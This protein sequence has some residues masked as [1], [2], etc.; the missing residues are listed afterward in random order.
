MR[1]SGRFSVP[2]L[3]SLRSQVMIG[4]THLP[5]DTGSGERENHFPELSVIHTRRLSDWFGFWLGGWWDW[6]VGY[7]YWSGLE[8][9][10]LSRILFPLLYLRV[11]ISSRWVLPVILTIPG[12]KELTDCRLL[13][14]QHHF[15]LATKPLYP[16]S[17][18]TPLSGCRAKLRLKF[19]G[20]SPCVPKP[21]P[22]VT[23]HPSGRQQWIGSEAVPGPMPCSWRGPSSVHSTDIFLV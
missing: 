12:R 14:W 21:S 1:D 6:E 19:R 10:G 3:D 15:S 20:E 4:M 23:Q 17:W 16:E 13:L 2:N 5:W 9:L 7:E 11:A 8:A 18:T 22:W